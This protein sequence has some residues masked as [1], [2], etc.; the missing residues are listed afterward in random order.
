MPRKPKLTK[1]KLLEL[2]KTHTTDQAIGALFGISR[3]A[4]HQCRKKYHVDTIE[5]HTDRN[6][7][8]VAMYK[9]GVKPENIMKKFG[10]SISQIYRVLNKFGK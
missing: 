8:I 5:K 7:E 9:K 10:I 1:E 6:K 3:Q 4:V 2:Q